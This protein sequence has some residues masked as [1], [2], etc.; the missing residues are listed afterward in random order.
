MNFSAQR[1]LRSLSRGR[2]DFQFDAQTFL[3]LRFKSDRLLGQAH[4]PAIEMQL[5][6]AHL[7]GLF[8]PTHVLPTVIDA[9]LSAIFSAIGRRTRIFPIEQERGR[10]RG[11]P[12]S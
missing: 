12:R 3:Q 4:S 10:L 1:S 11:N 5:K 8:R 7:A 6:V 2:H 9:P